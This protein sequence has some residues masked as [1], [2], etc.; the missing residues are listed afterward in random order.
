MCVLVIQFLNFQVMF[1]LCMYTYLYVYNYK[2]YYNEICIKL[3][4]A[5]MCPC[6]IIKFDNN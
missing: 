1:M 4:S 3:F 6:I 2:M 5:P